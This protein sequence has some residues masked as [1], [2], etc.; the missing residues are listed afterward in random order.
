[1]ECIQTGQRPLTTPEHA[2]HV[3]EIMLKAD[4][5]GRDGQTKTIESRF[6]PPRIEVMEE[7]MAAHL[8]HDRRHH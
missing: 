2:Y 8:V 7:Q 4:A 6:D 1:V 5:A 3:L